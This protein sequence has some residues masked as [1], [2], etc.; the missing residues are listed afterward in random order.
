MRIP[1]LLTSGKRGFLH[2]PH[3]MDGTWRALFLEELQE[4][5]CKH[6]RTRMMSSLYAPF[7]IHMLQS[8]SSFC[9]GTSQHHEY[10][11]QPSCDIIIIC[12]PDKTIFILL[13]CFIQLHQIQRLAKYY[14]C[15][16]PPSLIAMHFLSMGTTLTFIFSV[17][18]EHESPFFLYRVHWGARQPWE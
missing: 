12:F 9:W 11:L 14:H 10:L 3:F 2:G 17:L 13:D 15:T 8:E 16:P 1:Y 4:N 7:C 6:F 5:W 18:W